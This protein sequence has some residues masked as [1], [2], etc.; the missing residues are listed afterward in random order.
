MFAMMRAIGLLRVFDDPPPRKADFISAGPNLKV[1]WI[2]AISLKKL[3]NE[4][5][6]RVAWS[7]SPSGV[8]QNAIHH[9]QIHHESDDIADV[10]QPRHYP[11]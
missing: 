8:H 1:T 6:T 4:H 5:L 10:E 3:A 11:Q 9:Q 7:I 2:A